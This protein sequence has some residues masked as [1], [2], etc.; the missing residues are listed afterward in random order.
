MKLKIFG[1]NKNEVNKLHS[2]F[3]HIN[4]DNEGWYWDDSKGGLFHIKSILLTRNIL[5]DY[6]LDQLT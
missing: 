4:S 6:T 3:K 5:V 2:K 1:D